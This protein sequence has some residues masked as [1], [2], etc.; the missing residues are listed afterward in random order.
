[1]EELKGNPEKKEIIVTCDCSDLRHLLKITKYADDPTAS[2]TMLLNHYL[3]FW[4]RI[5]IAVAYIFKSAPCA[6]YDEVVI[7]KD[8]AEKLSKF[9]GEM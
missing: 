1:M 4:K 2:A 3:P 6:G 5:V 8:S 7:D 9:L